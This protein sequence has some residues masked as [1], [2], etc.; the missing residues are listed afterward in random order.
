MIP[1]ATAMGVLHID[2]LRVLMLKLFLD[3]ADLQAPAQPSPL[4]YNAVLL[5]NFKKL[6]EKHHTELRLPKDYAALHYITPNHLNAICSDLFGQSEG[7]V[8]PDRLIPATTS[9][10]GHHD[11]HYEP[12]PDN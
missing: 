1:L 8:I 11:L 3:L 5:R 2:K 7:T 4:S 6:V 9:H 10:L 12:H